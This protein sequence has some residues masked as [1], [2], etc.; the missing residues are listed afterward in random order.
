MLDAFGA[1]FGNAGVQLVIGGAMGGV[2]RWI[3]LQPKNWSDRVGAVVLGAILGYYVSPVFEPSLLDAMT[4]G[5]FFGFKLLVD[6]DK[7]PGFTATA[8]GFGGIGL[9]GFALDWITGRL[10]RFKQ[11][12]DVVT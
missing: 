10:N 9:L 7:L 4:S 8:L 12:T 5:K 2:A 11:Q 1:F 3:L 6:V